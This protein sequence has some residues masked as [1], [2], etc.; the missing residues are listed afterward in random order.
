M[1]VKNGRWRNAP[2]LDADIDVALR[3]KI[4]VFIGFSVFLQLR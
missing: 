4:Y 3:I 2:S 1:A